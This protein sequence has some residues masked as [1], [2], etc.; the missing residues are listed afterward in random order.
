MHSKTSRQ[1]GFGNEASTIG[2]NFSST[3]RLPGTFTQDDRQ[4]AETSEEAPVNKGGNIS[5]SR[6]S[7]VLDIISEESG[8]ERGELKD[9]T[10]FVSIGVDSL[11]SLIITSRLR[12]ELDFDVGSAASLFD[13]FN[14]VGELKAGL[15]RSLGLDV[16]NFGG[17]LSTDDRTVTIHSFTPA[18]TP[19]EF[20]DIPGEPSFIHHALHCTSVVLQRSWQPNGRTLFLFPDGSGSA[21]SYVHIPHVRADLNIIGLISPYRKEAAA[22][23]GCTLNGLINCYLFE[24]RRRQPTGPYSL[25]GWS[26][27]G[28]LAY[29]A[30][31]HLL[32]AGEAV[33]HLVL[34]DAPAPMRGLDRLPA[35]FYEHCAKAGVF[36]QIEHGGSSDAGSLGATPAQKSPRAPRAQAPDWLVPHFKATIE[37]LHN[38]CAAPLAAGATAPKTSL[39][40]AARSPFDGARFE[41]MPARC[42]GVDFQDEED[43]EMNRG[44]RFLTKPRT[45]FSPGDWQVLLPGAHIVVEVMRE[46]DHFSLMVGFILLSF[47]FLLPAFLAGTHLP[48]VSFCF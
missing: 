41:T 39:V 31:S 26:V 5:H 38:Y 24:I 19:G 33:A 47:L 40:W 34:I 30:T 15:A 13:E 43:E 18:S 32:A 46:A 14:N 12:D 44:M 1:A 42:E 2:P 48:P 7:Q 3:E 20:Q 4:S 27:G 29:T 23:A 8:I 22:M 17:F 21:H 6:A 45:D 37:L 11:L 36:A 35:R 16:T 25:G 10:S 28:M 9:D